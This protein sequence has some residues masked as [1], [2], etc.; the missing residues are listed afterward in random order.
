MASALQAVTRWGTAAGLNHT[1]SDMLAKTGTTDGNEQIWL[2]AATTAVAGAYWVGNISGH[3]NMR[4]I[5]P[6]H[7]TPP[8]SARVSVMRAMMSF[9]VG[10]YGGKRFDA[11]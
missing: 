8:A 6:T 4:H 5:R 7:G 9:A 2:V 1:T 10:K 11:R 3:A